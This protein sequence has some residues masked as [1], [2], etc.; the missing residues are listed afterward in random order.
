MPFYYFFKRTSAPE[1][2]G[3][4]WLDTCTDHKEAAEK[5]HAYHALTAE[6]GGPVVRRVHANTQEEA[7]GIID[8][9]GAK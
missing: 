7:Q 5:E 6:R 2:K 3:W 1:P 8:K 4:E 9:Y